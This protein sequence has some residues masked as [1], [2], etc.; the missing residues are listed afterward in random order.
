MHFLDLISIIKVH[1]KIVILIV[2]IRYINC[3]D[4]LKSGNV[5]RITYTHTVQYCNRKYE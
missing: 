2:V 3:N 1:Q 5:L 4:I